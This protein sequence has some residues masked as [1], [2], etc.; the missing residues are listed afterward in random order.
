MIVLI[1]AYILQTTITDLI[2][3]MKD[4]LVENNHLKNSFP[5]M[6]KRLNEYFGNKIITDINGKPNVIT[7]YFTASAILQQFINSKE[8][9]ILKKRS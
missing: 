7:F 4:K 6:K 1:P 8:M 3:L 5:H 2:N 9:K